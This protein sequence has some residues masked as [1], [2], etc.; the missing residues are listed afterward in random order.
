MAST[1]EELSGQADLLQNT[2]EFFRVGN[3][4]RYAMRHAETAGNPARRISVGTQAMRVH[5]D[6]RG[7]SGSADGDG[8]DA[9]KSAGYVGITDENGT[10]WDDEDGEFERY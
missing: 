3:T 5:P 1:S 10:K 9:G 8:N 4:G 7:I 6:I 2:I